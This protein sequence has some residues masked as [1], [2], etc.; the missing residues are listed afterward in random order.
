MKEKNRR[1]NKSKKPET[2]VALTPYVTAFLA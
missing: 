1:V 2:L